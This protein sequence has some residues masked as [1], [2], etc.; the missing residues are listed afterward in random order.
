ML[1]FSAPMHEF[2]GRPTDL[3]NLWVKGN[4]PLVET[5][6]EGK[7]EGFMGRRE[8]SFGSRKE[9]KEEECMMTKRLVS[10]PN[11]LISFS[12]FVD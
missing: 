11:I 4:N 12:S 8:K 1:E 3:G 2:S 9:A 5:N 7:H 10:P 6:G